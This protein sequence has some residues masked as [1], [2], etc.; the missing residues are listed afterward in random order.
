MSRLSKAVGKMHED[1]LNHVSEQETNFMG[2]TSYKLDPLETLKMVSASSIFGE[3][4]YYRKGMKNEETY[5]ASYFDREYGRYGRHEVMYTFDDCII[6]DHYEG[7]TTSQ[8]FEQ[9]IDE[10]LDYDFWGVLQWAMKLRHDYY[11]RL[12]PQIIMVRAAI[13]PKREEFTKTHP[14][15]F[16]DIEQSVMSRGDEPAVQCAYYLYLNEGN[17]NKMPSVLKRAIAWKLSNLKPYD[18]NKY[19]NA[20]IGMI[21]TVRLV[22]A[23]STPIDEL[24]KTG[25]IVV[26]EEKKTWEQLHSSGMGWREIVDKGIMGH[27]AMLRNIRN[28]FTDIEDLDFCKKYMVTLKDGVPK[29]KQFP[30]RYESAYKMIK[31]SSLINHK[32]YILDML[33]ECIDIAIDNLP[34]LKG[35]TMCLSDNSGSAWG[36]FN[37]EFGTERVAEIDN[38][39]SVIAAKCSDEGYVGKF[40]D[41]LIE[42]PV[43][44]RNGALSQASA[45]SKD[46]DYDVGGSTEGGI[47]KFF[48]DAINQK[49]WYDNIFIF[50]DQQA[51]A[52][53]LYGT[54][55]DMDEYREKYFVRSHGWRGHVDVYKLIREYRKQVNPK[56]N[57]FSVQTAGYTN[58]VIPQMSYRT[59]IL[60]GWTGK[61]IQ[62]AA[63]Y[64]RQWDEIEEKRHQ[65]DTSWFPWFLQDNNNG[66]N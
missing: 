30:F 13:H 65:K 19:K 21:N 2:G 20:E 1:K 11:M 6:G 47:W 63:E 54:D 53:G 46:R 56:V 38:L 51:G 35:K 37:S 16:R 59:A 8:V 50:S 26:P 7:K 62:F 34:K 22:H 42:F 49:I 43:S 24:M 55:A 14:G 18:I 17:K 32:T 41:K 10:A 23:T 64:I 48:R 27:M 36:T 9:I 4:Q 61:E 57:V 58:A 5:S 28:V 31:D 39:S 52:G 15:M 66:Q 25:T 40:G 60:Y 29:G 12:N 33:E 45:I 3:P 44:K